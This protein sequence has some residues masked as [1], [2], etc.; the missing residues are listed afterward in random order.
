MDSNWILADSGARNNHLRVLTYEE[1]VEYANNHPERNVT[2]QSIFNAAV[3][4]PEYGMSLTEAQYD[5]IPADAAY[6]VLVHHLMTIP[7]GRD[8]STTIRFLFEVYPEL[9]Y[10]T[11]SSE[12]ESER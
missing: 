10:I 6:K 8:P 4:A 3:N 12:E 5:A 2:I 11:E 9:A 1:A 7:T